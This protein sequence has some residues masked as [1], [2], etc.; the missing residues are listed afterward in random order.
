MLGKPLWSVLGIAGLGIGLTASL[1]L[2]MKSDH[3]G[4]GKSTDVALCQLID[5]RSWGRVGDIHAFSVRT[6]TWNVGESVL[7]W[8]EF[9]PDHPVMA[10]HLYRYR[11]GRLEMIGHSWLK[12]GFCAL[13]LTGCG[14]CDTQP[15][16]PNYLLPGCRDPYSANLNGNQMRLGPRSEVNAST[17]TFGYPY[18]LGWQETGNAIFKRLQVHDDDLN[19]ELNKDARYYIEAQIVHPQ[20]GTSDA[21]H[22]NATYEE[23]FPEADEDTYDLGNGVD[24]VQ[25]LPAIYA[26]QD[27][28]PAVVIEVVDIDEGKPFDDGRFHV[29]YRVFDNG[30]GTWRYEYAV[31][32]LNSHRSGRSFSI[33][34]PEGA[35]I[36]ETFH[37]DVKYHSGE[38]Y[39]NE[40]WTLS[41]GNGAIAWSGMSHSEN[42]NANALR[43]GTMFN[44]AFVT[45]R[46]PVMGEVTLGLFR[47]ITPDSV[48][49]PAL[50][51]GTAAPDCPGDLDGN[52]VV[53][54]SDLLILL[55]NWGECPDNDD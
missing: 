4:G 43:W 37:R 40:D 28:D 42:K 31:H 34:L 6:D 9:T 38:V 13:Q 10:Q 35:A 11:D 45:N 33:P 26:W 55:A 47:P 53:D 3:D 54:G 32:N 50:V 51:P 20:E 8:E 15:G 21:R 7:I 2:G 49:V 29:G 27:N 30:D 12:H 19:P 44:F 17:G 48:Q 41:I 24:T 22:N 14:D 23:V 16:C 36:Y 46:P 18:K 1:G 39:T 5:T 25:F 52:G